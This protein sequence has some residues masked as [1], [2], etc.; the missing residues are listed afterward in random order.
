MLARSG[1]GWSRLAFLPLA[2]DPTLRRRLTNFFGRL[3]ASQIP[4][5]RSY[6]GGGRG[7]GRGARAGELC[8]PRWPARGRLCVVGSGQRSEKGFAGRGEVSRW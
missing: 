6:P 1:I 3:A 5:G 7:G 8:E 4:G 2:A